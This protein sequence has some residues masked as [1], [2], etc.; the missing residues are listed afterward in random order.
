ME[1]KKLFDPKTEVNGEGGI[2][3]ADVN[4]KGGAPN[5]AVNGD[6]GAPATGAPETQE[7]AM[8]LPKIEQRSQPDAPDLTTSLSTQAEVPTGISMPKKPDGT[9]WPTSNASGNLSSYR[10]LI[11]YLEQKLLESKRLSDDDLKKLRRRQKTEGIISGISD[12]VQSLANLVATSKY[13][14]NMYNAT[15]GMSAKMKERFEK[16]KAE[17]DAEDEK[18]FNY[19]MMLGKLR[20]A[21]DDK[22][23]SRERDALQDQLRY[24]A[25]LRAEVKMR[26]DEAMDKLKMEFLRG[27]IT[28]QEYTA[29]INKINKEYAEE[30]WKSKI[31]K[32]NRQPRGGSGGKGGKG[33]KGSDKFGYEKI[34]EITDDG[35]GHKTTVTRYVRRQ[36]GQSNG[37]KKTGL[38]DKW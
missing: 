2:V 1:E 14:P 11:P 19:A 28:D 25:A 17:R 5:T 8:R 7:K 9:K 30:W 32:N 16:E 12:A 3:Y 37:K 24:S 13:A 27:K 10:E 18:Y 38:G 33:G 34:V 29:E 31:N 21:A 26:R 35:V 20:E 23:Y 4:S 36:N 6:S 15:E 22:E